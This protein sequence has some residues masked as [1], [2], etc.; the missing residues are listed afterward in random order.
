[1]ESKNLIIA[2]VWTFVLVVTVGTF[3][4]GAEFFVLLL[5]FF[6]ALIV[7]VAVGGFFPAEKKEAQVELANELKIIRSRLDDL[8]S[9]A[10]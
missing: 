7:S 8:T 9:E 10:E 1:M 5:L 6:I 3:W 4:I 2:C